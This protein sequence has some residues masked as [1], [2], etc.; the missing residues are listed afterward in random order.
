VLA[1]TFDTG[2]VEAAADRLGIPPGHE[3]A[4][5]CAALALV[6]APGA[7][8]GCGPWDVADAWRPSS[9]VADTTVA[10]VHEGAPVRVRISGDPA[11][12]RAEVDDGGARPAG[13]R[14]LEPPVG[15]RGSLAVTG[16]GVTAVWDVAISPA[17]VWVGRDG[18]AWRF[19]VPQPG[20]AGAAATA[21]TAG[22]VGSPMPGVVAAVHVAVGDV[23]AAGTVL[24]VVEAMKMEHPVRA[25]VDG[26]VRALYVHP[27]QTVAIDEPL[28]LVADDAGPAVSTPSTEVGQ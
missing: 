1:G 25:P 18:W 19:V 14:W 21:G 13:A 10:L 3:H 2:L 20:R 15:G 28:A 12:C 11:A 9:Q 4:A 26:T 8:G 24:M 27:G 17:T 7:T 23:V 5:R 22:P 16:S 6:S